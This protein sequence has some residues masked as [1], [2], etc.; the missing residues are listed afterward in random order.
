[1]KSSNSIVYLLKTKD[2]YKIGVTTTTIEKRIKQLQTGN[3]NIIS[4]V[5]YEKVSCDK[6]MY[7]IE[8]MLHKEYKHKN[9]LGEWFTLSNDEVNQIILKLK[10]FKKDAYL[11][12]YKSIKYEISRGK[13]NIHKYKKKNRELEDKINKELNKKL[14]SFLLNPTHY[15]DMLHFKKILL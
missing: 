11:K 14:Q 9:I 6:T 1:M 10:V 15:V 4:C 12:Y 5:Y 8:K 2:A 7:A 13:K 3:P